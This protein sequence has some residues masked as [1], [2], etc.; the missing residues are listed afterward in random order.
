MRA[1]GFLLEVTMKTLFLILF[2]L[3]IEAYS[4]ELGTLISSGP[5]ESHSNQILIKSSSSRNQKLSIPLQISANKLNNKNLERKKCNVRL[6][7]K[8]KRNEQ[9]KIS[10]IDQE[11]ETIL[12]P[13]SKASIN[14]DVSAV[15]HKTEINIKKESKKSEKFDLKDDKNM[16]Q[17]LCGQEIML[18][19]NSSIVVEGSGSGQVHSQTAQ[20]EIESQ[21]CK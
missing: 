9:L 11:I 12:S 16:I 21:S 14:L 13:N 3:S 7:I 6:P 18:T 1:R 4:F 5:C 20:I 17:S 2:M 19:V 8:V 10:N 15:G